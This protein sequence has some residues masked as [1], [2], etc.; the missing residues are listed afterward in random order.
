MGPKRAATPDPTSRKKVKRV[1]TNKTLSSSPSAANHRSGSSAS[2][3][4]HSSTSATS[5]SSNPPALT[6]KAPAFKGFTLRVEARRRPSVESTALPSPFERANGRPI[7]NTLNYRVE[8][9][10]YWDAMREYRRFSI[11]N[12]SIELGDCIYVTAS[13]DEDVALDAPIRGWVAKVLHVRAHDP[14]HVFLLVAWMYRPEDLPNGRKPYHGNYE[15]IASNDL[16]IIDAMTV[17]EKAP[18]VYWDEHDDENES[19]DPRT[20]FWRQTIDVQRSR[21]LLSKLRT[22]CIDN[23]P[24]NPDQ[25]TVQCPHC[26]VWLHGACI[27][28]A[29]VRSLFQQHNLAY[30]PRT[31]VPRFSAQF[32]ASQDQPCRLRVTDHHAKPGEMKHWNQEADCLLCDRNID[33]SS[34][35]EAGE[36]EGFHDGVDITAILEE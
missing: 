22:H 16:Q 18:V 19:L 3:P 4:A 15:L 21:P 20:L 17:E 9:A 27:E 26:K 8:P 23:K 7:F 36:E 31:S 12:Q 6:W 33:D 11:Q 5:Q 34:E 28:E 30:P 25:V 32:T 10:R 1:P 35:P 2:S 14:S 24:C 13:A 29:A